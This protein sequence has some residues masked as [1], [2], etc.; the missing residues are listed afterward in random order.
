VIEGLTKGLADAAAVAD[1][2]TPRLV[3][4]D[5]EENLHQLFLDNHWTDTLP[6][7]LPTEA[8]VTAMLAGTSHAPGEIVGRL[9]ATANRGQWEFTVEKVAVNAVMAGA[10]PEYFPVIL[11]LAASGLSARS[12]TRRPRPWSG[13]R[14]DP[15]R[16]RMKGIGA[17]GPYNTP[18]PRWALRSTVENLQGGSVPGET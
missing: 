1:R 9:Q 8:R 18:M 13:E 7:V 14:A 6:I 12:S 16:D 11:A 4:P 15:Q 17:M 5:T 2:S 3:E 10:R